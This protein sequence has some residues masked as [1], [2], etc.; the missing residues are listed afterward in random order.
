[1]DIEKR[2]VLDAE[3]NLIK[4]ADKIIAS[5]EEEYEVDSEKAD[6][7]LLEAP[8]LKERIEFTS[9]FAQAISQYQAWRPL[10]NNDT[11]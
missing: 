1:M 3:K 6:K 11:V 7:K 5:L 2:A 8:W 9:A 10:N 4:E